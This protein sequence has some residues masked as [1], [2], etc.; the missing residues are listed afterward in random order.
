MARGEPDACVLET[1]A[2]RAPVPSTRAASSRE[3]AGAFVILV[4]ATPG[5]EPLKDTRFLD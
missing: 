3:G 1:V 4:D 2:R 5:W